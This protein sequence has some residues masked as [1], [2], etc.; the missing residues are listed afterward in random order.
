MYRILKLRRAGGGTKEPIY[1]FLL[2]VFQK[3]TSIKTG[4]TIF[5]FK[6]GLTTS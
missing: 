4:K 6:I 1:L 5:S 2:R 3:C